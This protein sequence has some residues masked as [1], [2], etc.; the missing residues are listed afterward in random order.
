MN[1]L[2]A[3]QSQ[4]GTVNTRSRRA[5]FVLSSLLL[6]G[7]TAAAQDA[8]RPKSKTLN[9]EAL[10]DVPPSAYGPFAQELW[11]DAFAFQ[12][13]ENGLQSDLTYTTNFYATNPNLTP[14]QERFFARLPLESGAVVTG[15]TCY[16]NDASLINNLSVTL[17]VR[18]CTWFTEIAS[19]STQEKTSNDIAFRS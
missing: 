11:V 4:G 7:A 13:K 19:L 5:V 10:S 3:T 6:T 14:A 9:L 17:V 1:G 16:V 2:I 8:N 15:V 12:G 18:E